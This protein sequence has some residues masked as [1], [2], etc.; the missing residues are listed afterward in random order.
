MG[1]AGVNFYEAYIEL[2]DI[3]VWEKN[4][5]NALQHYEKALAI[6]SDYRVAHERL[7]SAYVQ[8][9]KFEEALKVLDKDDAYGP[10]P[11][12]IEMR[13]KLNSVTRG[14]SWSGETITL[15]SDNYI[16]KTNVSQS[17]AQTLSDC[18]EQIRDHYDE[19]FPDID[20][21]DR[22]YLIFVFD[23]R[24]SY[25]ADGSPE[26]SGGYYDPQFRRLMLYQY[27]QLDTTLRVFK[28]EGFHQYCHEYLDY[29]PSWFNE[30]LADY[31]S[32]SEPVQSK[33]KTVMRIIPNDERLRWL[34]SAMRQGHD[35]SARRL[36]NM[37]QA[38]M[39]REDMHLNYAHGWSLVY[40]SIHGANGKYRPVLVKYFKELRKKTP[41]TE[42]YD[43]TYGRVNMKAFE[44]EWTDFLLAL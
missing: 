39:Y 24:E 41:W 8:L 17:M 23:S 20:K 14:P 19:M 22:K 28:H 21:P 33:G 35:F 16:V 13:K 4:P 34:K 31:F 6:Y 40:F 7:C 32:A 27:P 30:G 37:T 15:E 44:K 26:N 11:R 43:K 18:A 29:I 5:Q 1:A 3:D 12:S 36:M 38:E 2:G 25:L 42:V 9:G 10:T